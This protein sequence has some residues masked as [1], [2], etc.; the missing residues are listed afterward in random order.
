MVAFTVR[1]EPAIHG[2]AL[3]MPYESELELGSGLGSED[4]T[5]PLPARTPRAKFARLPRPPA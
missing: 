4:A 3:H 2:T 1:I 5:H